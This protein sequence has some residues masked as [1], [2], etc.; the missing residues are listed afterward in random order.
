ML[1]HESHVFELRVEGQLGACLT[2]QLGKHNTCKAEVK[3]RVPSRS[4]SLLHK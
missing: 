3:V 2:D 4:S 1:M